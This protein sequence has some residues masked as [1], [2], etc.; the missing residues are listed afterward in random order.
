MTT[1]KQAVLTIGVPVVGG[2]V[3][4][5]VTSGLTNLGMRDGDDASL[6]AKMGGIV[7]G[8]VAG[9]IFAKMVLE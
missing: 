5:A 3:G 1:E 6:A 8:G 9:F 4:L 2:L 7:A